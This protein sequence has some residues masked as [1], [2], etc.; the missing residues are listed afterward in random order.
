MVI[1][2]GDAGAQ[3]RRRFA[4]VHA[5]APELITRE[6]ESFRKLD[7]MNTDFVFWL[8]EELESFELS[9]RVHGLGSERLAA[10]IDGKRLGSAKLR[11]GRT[12]TI[13]INGRE[14]TVAPGRHILTLAISR[15]R[16]GNPEADVSWVRLGPSQSK[17]ASLELPATRRETFTEVTIGEERLRS[18]VLRPSGSLR[19]SVWVPPQTQL[20]ARVGIWGEGPGE[21]EVVVHTPRGERFVVASQAREEDDPRDFKPLVADLSRF[22]SQFVDLELSAPHTLK[23]ARLAIGEP[24]LRSQQEESKTAPRPRRALVVLFSGL[25]GKH[26]P[27]AAA[28]NGLPIMNQMAQDG[29][30]FQGYRTTS[31]SVVSVLASLFTGLPPWHHGVTGPE[32][33]L[34][35]NLMT[36]ASSIEGRGGRSSLFT[37]VPLSFAPL[38]L[39][40]GF[41]SFESYAPQEDVPAVQPIRE[42]QSWFKKHLEHE[43]PVLGVIHLRGGHPPF[44][45]SKEEAAEL[46]PA[47]YGGNL[48]ARRAAIQLSEIRSRRSERHRR[49]PDEDWAR[50]NALQKAALLKQSAELSKFFEWLRQEG[51]YDETLII[52][53]G[54]VGAGEVPDIPFAHDAP[55]EEPYLAVPLV[56]KFPRAFHG[57]EQVFGYFAP[58][59]LTQTLV[60]AL[61]I[62]FDQASD[63]ISLDSTDAPRRAFLRPH[64][65]YRKGEYSMRLG[66]MLLLGEDG[67][68]PR[69]CFPAL[70]PTCGVDRSEQH[71]LESRALWF[72][73][74]NAL[75]GP[76][77]DPESP[78]EVGEDTRFENGLEVWGVRR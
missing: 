55:L 69:L 25:S 2:L 59:D 13:V 29:V 63:A 21:V 65:A 56:V 73:L 4:L 17:D 47:E 53:A 19:C 42:A 11:A 5:K 49:M 16:G 34:S 68:A 61:R 45:V 26:A 48:S 31:T 7:Q 44:D 24:R 20:V 36:L 12:E 57:G 77:T 66:D 76:L 60:H 37:A 52:L 51:A 62:E 58:R 38:G 3:A 78:E 74:Y 43:G 41:G 67:A 1:D 72:V 28:A 23:R 14:K 22:A 35:P 39:Q 32:G 8:T 27:P 40:R 6:G 64:I 46:S 30:Y 33:G 10:Y 15:P 54:D 75:S 9:A 50:M 70:D 71:V 18:V